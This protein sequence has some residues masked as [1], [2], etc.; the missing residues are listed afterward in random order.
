MI[1]TTIGARTSRASISH[2][3]SIPSRDPHPGESKNDATHLVRRVN[4]VYRPVE[5][6]S[7]RFRNVSMH[8]TH[9][10]LQYTSLERLRKSNWPRKQWRS[11]DGLMKSFHLLYASYGDNN[12]V[13]AT[14]QGSDR[15]PSSFNTRFTRDLSLQR[16]QLPSMA[17]RRVRSHF[18][19]KSPPCM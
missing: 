1:P 11:Y 17:R 8:D 4:E 19:S 3:R 16:E 13:T 9:P 5:E 7:W 18:L 2:M 15:F 6:D 10:R 14:I 12:A